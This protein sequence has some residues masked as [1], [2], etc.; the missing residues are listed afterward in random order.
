V[1]LVGKTPI[2]GLVAPIWEGMWYGLAAVE[3][4]AAEA[5]AVF[6]EA[7]MGR[8]S[9]AGLAVAGEEVLAE[10]VAVGAGFG[11]GTLLELDPEGTPVGMGC[12]PFW[13]MR[14]PYSPCEPLFR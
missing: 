8:R 6:V 9:I 4:A 11:L 2:R 7:G 12:V 5:V 13:S 3:A 10:E 14:R 1:V